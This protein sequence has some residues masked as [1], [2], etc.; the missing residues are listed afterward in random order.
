[1]PSEAEREEGFRSTAGAS[2]PEGLE[3]R[4]ILL[5]DCLLGGAQDRRA[6]RGF[7]VVLGPKDKIFNAEVG[8]QRGQPRERDS[9][10]LS[11]F[12]SPRGSDAYPAGRYLVPGN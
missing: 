4:P 12:K 7:G 11:P 9:N 5:L 2:V 10:F 8:G 6:I 1:M 3:D